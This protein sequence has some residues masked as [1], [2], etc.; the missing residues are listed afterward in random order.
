[1]FFADAARVLS[2]VSLWVVLNVCG[3]VANIIKH[4]DNLIIPD[5]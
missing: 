4:L 2:K 1:M 5:P 3:F